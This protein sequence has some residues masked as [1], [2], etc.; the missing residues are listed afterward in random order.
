MDT[1]KG[2]RYSKDHYGGCYGE[3]YAANIAN[4]YNMDFSVPVQRCFIENKGQLYF[5]G[6]Y[7]VKHE[8]SIINTIKNI[9][10]PFIRIGEMGD[11]SEYWN[12]TMNVCE[13]I[14]NGGKPIVIITKHWNILSDKLLKLL[15]KY[16][17]IINTSISALDS[18][19]QISHRLNQYNKLKNYCKSILRVVSLDFNTLDK[20]GLYL[21][22]IQTELLNNSNVL[23]T[24]FRPSKDNDLLKYETIN[25]KKKYFLKSDVL[26]SIRNDNIYTGHCSKCNEMCGLNI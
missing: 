11:P 16:N 26:F 9:D 8:E 25:V 21:N 10:M 22:N 18:K 2:C 17:I 6:F 3:C 12:H 14:S 15:S 19:E 20:C 24:A 7:D 23:E 4:R 13:K 1:V 5:N